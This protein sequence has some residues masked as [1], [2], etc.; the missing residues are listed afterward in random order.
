MLFLNRP[1]Q[2]EGKFPLKASEIFHEWELQ[3]M[4]IIFLGVDSSL[5]F[6]SKNFLQRKMLFLFQETYLN[7]QRR[8]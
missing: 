4:D 7:E 2:E 5:Y 6:L 1:N 8:K 3:D